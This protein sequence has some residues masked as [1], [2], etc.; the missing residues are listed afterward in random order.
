MGFAPVG[1]RH[2]PQLSAFQQA[3][4]LELHKRLCPLA[5]RLGGQ[6][7][8]LRH[9]RMLLDAKR[10]TGYTYEASRLHKTHA[11]RMVGGSQQSALDVGRHRTTCKVT[12][13]APLKNGAVDRLAFG[14]SKAVG[15]GGSWQRCRGCVGLICGAQLHRLPNLNKYHVYA[16]FLIA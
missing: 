9:Q 4:H 15:A 10:L 7:P 1:Q 16:L 3:L 2:S 12:H 5:Q 14:G 8:L 13:I 11:G 6:D